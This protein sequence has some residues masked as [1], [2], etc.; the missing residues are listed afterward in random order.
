M[1]PRKSTPIAVR[2]RMAASS[3]ATI[4]RWPW[5]QV[6]SQ[7]FNRPVLLAAF[8]VIAMNAVAQDFRID[9]F[10]VDGG[11]G[12]SVG[13]GFSVSGTIAQ[14]D[15]GRLSGGN[16]ALEGGFW[17]VV[18][19][20]SLAGADTVHRQPGRTIKIPVASLLA[21]DTSPAG[22]PLVMTA[23]SATSEGGVALKLIH[24]VVLYAPTPG[25][26]KNDAFTYTADNGLDTITGVVSVVV[27]AP[28]EAVTH[29]ILG[30]NYSSGSGGIVVVAAVIPGR[31]YT[32]Q[33]TSSL[34]SPIAW[35]IVDGP[36]IGTAS[37]QARFTETS[38]ASPRFYRVVESTNP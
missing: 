35:T 33:A 34:D 5:R 8:A 38:P 30:V 1:N 22:F 7:K 36:Q 10:T 9:W 17:A 12:V 37:G 19:S 32:L 2:G 23:V 6:I 24:G 13:G 31:S 15:A 18:A 27:D 28:T 26:N 25:F 21:N 11:G 14:A 29:N 3:R 16:Y 4:N 20:D